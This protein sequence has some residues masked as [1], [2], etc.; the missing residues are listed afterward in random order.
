MSRVRGNRT[1]GSI[2]RERK[3]RSPDAANPQCRR[4]DG[5]LQRSAEVGAEI[6]AR[7]GGCDAGPG[8]NDAIPAQAGERVA[9]Q[10]RAVGIASWDHR[11]L[12]GAY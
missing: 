5:A 11:K 4:R 3:L 7:Y 8:F 10:F 9:L 1:N 12:G 2:G 6:L